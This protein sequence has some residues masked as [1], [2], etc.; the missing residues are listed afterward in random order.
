VNSGPAAVVH[1]YVILDVWGAY[2]F[3]PSWSRTVDYITRE[4]PAQWQGDPETVLDF[5]WPPVAGSASGIVFWSAFT[6]LEDTQLVGSVSRV[7][8]GYE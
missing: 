2:W 7:E 3:W 4:L 5:T 1:H 8:W 6:N